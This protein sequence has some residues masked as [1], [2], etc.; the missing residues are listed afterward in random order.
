VSP[1]KGIIALI[2]A[3]GWLTCAAG[4]VATKRLSQVLLSN[5]LH[6][7]GMGYHGNFKDEGQLEG[8]RHYAVWEVRVVITPVSGRQ[9]WLLL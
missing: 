6:D 4:I 3:S 1:N 5:T 8:G 2:V 9:G 7:N